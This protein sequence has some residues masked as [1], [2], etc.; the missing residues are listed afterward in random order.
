MKWSRVEL[1]GPAPACRLD[2]AMCNVGLRVG[3]A[4][5]DS[6]DDMNTARSQAKDALEH[7]MRI[8]R[9]GSARTAGSA[10]S[11]GSQRSLASAGSLPRDEKV[12]SD[13]SSPGWLISHLHQTC[14]SVGVEMAAV[15]D[16]HLS[17]QSKTIDPQFG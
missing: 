15:V 5:A 17:F 12:P 9:G 2:F 14:V 6:T 4:T 3:R 11:A 13:T 1:E 10:G 7:Q 8:G 16:K